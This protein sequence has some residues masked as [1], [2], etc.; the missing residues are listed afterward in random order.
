M[1]PL[2]T[3]GPPAP[4]FEARELVAV[5]NCARTEALGILIWTREGAGQ[6]RALVLAGRTTAGAAALALARHLGNY[7]VEC[8]TVLCGPEHR[9]APLA[10]REREILL[11]IGAPLDEYLDP[12]AV[13]ALVEGLGPDDALVDGAGDNPTPGRETEFMDCARAAS[14]AGLTVRLAPSAD[15][16]PPVPRADDAIFT[17]EAVPC[18]RETV[19]LMDSAA[20]EYYRMP[21]LALMENA[22]WRVAREAFACLGFDPGAGRVLVLAGPGN[23]GGD[24]FV[25]ARHLTGWGAA[26]DVV[27]VGSRAKAV[28]DALASIKLAEES[29]VAARVAES[30][31][32]VESILGELL[33]GA[34]PVDSAPP[35]PS[36]DA[37]AV[38]SGQEV[39]A[40]RA[41]RGT[42]HGAALVVDALLG[43]GLS[44]KVR[45]PIARAIELVN[46]SRARLLAVDT[47]SGLDANTG[48]ALGLATTAERTV[49][50]AFP[51]M[52]FALGEGPA[53]VGLLI[54]ADISIP[55]ALW[56]RGTDGLL[57][58]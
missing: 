49:T 18:S 1:T 40:R 22:G 42:P 44:G 46:E 52:G 2:G 20:M 19:R 29:G 37:P 25:A 15:Y 55:R 7:G 35:A 5:E 28:D 48:E 6:R 41:E 45:G 23:N 10:A 27:L 21:G 3:A 30:D 38:R 31:E 4:A 50:F 51:K 8:R 32:A 43:T 26:V 33:P 58:N 16:R 53:R 14:G 36:V 11:R 12:N 39:G 24:G 9:I 57:G 47:P 54:V 34:A 17:P 13:R 56:A